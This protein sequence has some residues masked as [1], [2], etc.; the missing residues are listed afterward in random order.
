MRPVRL[1]LISVLVAG[2]V[3]VAVT[4]AAL[5]P[6]P[7]SC[8]SGGGAQSN[9]GPLPGGG[10]WANASVATV[11]F[12]GGAHVSFNWST[13]DGSVA[14]FRVVSPA[15]AQLY[16]VTAASG[17]GTFTAGSSTGSDGG[18]GFGIGLTPANETV[19]YEYACTTLK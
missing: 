16:G 19:D 13:P 14:T 2:L 12:P 10:S 4:T 9:G 11:M 3:V 5:W 6:K 17:S 1:A 8:G 15:G 18:Y 7:V